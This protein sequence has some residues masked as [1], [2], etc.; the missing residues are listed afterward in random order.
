MPM[1]KCEIGDAY[2]NEEKCSYDAI[3]GQGQVH[4]V[5]AGAFVSDI[6]GLSLSSPTASFVS[7]LRGWVIHHWLQLV[8]L[9][10]R[11]AFLFKL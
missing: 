9:C 10:C 2:L 7:T 4:L 1:P 6:F 5:Y 3:L 11:A 8:S